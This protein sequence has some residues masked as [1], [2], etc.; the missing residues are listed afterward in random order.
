[1][2]AAITVPDADIAAFYQQNLAQYQ[3]PEQV[4]A[5]HILFKTEGKDENAVKA[6]AED[7]LKKAKAPGADFA[8]LAKQY[9]EDEI[10]QGTIGGDLDYFGRGRMVPE[11]EQAAFAMK[12]GDISD[13]VKTAFGF[14]IIKVVDKQPEIDAAAGRGAG[15]DR[16][17]AEVAEGAERGRAHRHGRSRPPSRPRPISTRSPRNAACGG[18][19][20]G[21]SPRDGA[22]RRPGPAARDGGRASST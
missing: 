9:S 19:D 14:H 11:F 22:D 1:M 13:L 15:G 12:A 20:R 21:C 18:R 10:E 16:G 3:T 6:Q 5:S 2:R 17:P 4:R 8:A 7:V